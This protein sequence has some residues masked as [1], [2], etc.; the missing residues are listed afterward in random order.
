MVY[1]DDVILTDNDTVVIASLKQH[2]NDKFGIKDLGNLH[3]F[4]GIEITHTP[5]GI[6]LCQ[7]KFVREF[8]QDSSLDISHSTCTSLPVHLKLSA[9][10]SDLLD[11]HDVY[12]S[13]VGKLNY[14]TN[15]RPDLS[16]TVQVLSQ[17]MLAP[18][19]SHMSKRFLMLIGPLVLILIILLLV[20]FYSLAILV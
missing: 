16:Y 20:I 1:V 11:K 10:Y 15:T 8:L 6:V 2:L 4:L 13:L 19:T 14:L 18:R 3:Y 7:Q 12:R 5:N 17:Y 9:T